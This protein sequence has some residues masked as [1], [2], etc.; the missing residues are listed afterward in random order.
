MQQHPGGWALVHRE[1]VLQCFQR[2]DAPEALHQDAQAAVR[3]GCAEDWRRHRLCRHREQGLL[4][5]EG[6]PDILREAGSS[7]PGEEG[8]R[9]C[10]TGACEGEG[11]RDGRVIRDAEGALRPASRQGPEEGD[12]N[13]V[14]LLR[15]P[16]GERSPPGRAAAGA[17][18]TSE[19]DASG[20]SR[21]TQ[22]IL[23]G[24]S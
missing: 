5:G 6:N 18:A 8:E 24:G 15:H 19:R 4:Q 2:R 22:I 1:A 12:G 11:D 17:R 14:H 20:V 16:H 23:R 13:P 3:G 21:V 9:L 7:L 10:E